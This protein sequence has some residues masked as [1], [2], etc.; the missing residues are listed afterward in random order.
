[1]KVADLMQRAVTVPPDM[2]LDEVARRMLAE[3]VDAVAVVDGA[4]RLRGL[5]SEVDF[6]VQERYLPFTAQSAP[7]VFGQWVSASLDVET[8]YARAGRITAERVMH[9]PALV[10]TPIDLLGLTACR[11]SHAHADLVPVIRDGELVGLLAA[12]DLVRL[13]AHVA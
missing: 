6:N 7:T 4:G 10:V 12:R 2:P 9:S 13:A 8:A 3:G 11:M 1:M 5:I